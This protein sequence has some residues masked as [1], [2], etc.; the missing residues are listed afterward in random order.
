MK[1]KSAQAKTKVVH[2]EPR[3][4]TFVFVWKSHS[5]FLLREN[6][7]AG[8]GDEPSPQPPLESFKYQT[9]TVFRPFTNGFYEA[10]V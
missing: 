6:E 5:I 2:R 4:Q 1:L 3:W 7:T 8:P 10:A 9:D